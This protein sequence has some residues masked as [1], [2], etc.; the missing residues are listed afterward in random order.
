[1][2]TQLLENFI[3]HYKFSLLP[4]FDSAWK[5]LFS[6]SLFPFMSKCFLVLWVNECVCTHKIM[7]SQADMPTSGN[8]NL[9]FEA[10]K[11]V[12]FNKNLY[13]LKTYTNR[14]PLPHFIFHLQQCW[15]QRNTTYTSHGFLPSLMA[16]WSP[17]CANTPPWKSVFFYFWTPSHL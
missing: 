8:T 10:H 17:S 5:I 6:Y 11:P 12:F 2:I 13:F 15:N 7:M 3:K 1:M 14:L 9:Y 4:Y 16:L